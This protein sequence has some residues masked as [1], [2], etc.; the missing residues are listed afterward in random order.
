MR[1]AFRNTDRR[2]SRHPDRHWVLDVFPPGAE[3]WLPGS[4]VCPFGSRTR[5]EHVEREPEEAC[6]VG[7]AVVFNGEYFEWT[8]IMEAVLEA[9]DTFTFLE[10]GAGFG[11]W[12]SRAAALARIKGKRFRAGLAEPDP[13]HA[14]WARQHM[15]DNGIED[16]VLF[17]AAVG[18]RR[19]AT[20]L[21]VGRPPD[22][23]TPG[24]WYGQSVFWDPFPTSATVGDYHGKPMF[25]GE[26]GWRVIE[27]E[28]IPLSDALKP[29]DFVDLI[30][31]DIQGA[32]G[33]AVRGS[34]DALTATTRRLHIETHTAAVEA[35][36]RDSL[37]SSGW[38]KLR[39]YGCLQENQTAFGRCY[40]VGG[41]Q[42][43]INPKQL[44]NRA[45]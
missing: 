25:R 10:L 32:E 36:L 16:Y 44:K 35:D 37:S 40:M 7:D 20:P 18:G 39:D 38:R 17:E 3:P 33:D 24:N 8:D 41:V 29:F 14:G 42:S 9:G 11:R 19:G 1:R 34:L 23:E 45:R 30:D 26:G 21:V 6:E 12:T 13:K 22:Q 2:S 31:M 27:A 5:A 28:E 15:A 43:W 4:R